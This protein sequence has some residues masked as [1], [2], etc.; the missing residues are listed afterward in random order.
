MTWSMSWQHTACCAMH[1]IHNSLTLDPVLS[2]INPDRATIQLPSGLFPS[3]FLTKTLYAPVLSAIHAT[4][5]TNLIF[6]NLI[7]WPIQAHCCCCKLTYLLT[8]WRTVLLEKLSSSQ[9]VKKFPAFCGTQRFIT[10][11]TDARP[12]PQPDQSSSY[13][14]IPLPEDPS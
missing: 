14:H 13:P 12:C 2:Q 6:L 3:G 9:L 1:H 11:F 4:C 8:P 5:P 7:T 10:A